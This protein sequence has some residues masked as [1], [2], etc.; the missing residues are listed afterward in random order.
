VAQ[1]LRHRTADTDQLKNR[2][3]TMRTR[4]YI[5]AITMAASALGL[6]AV[7]S[8]PDIRQYLKIRKM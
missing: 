8:L 6:L 1:R 7:M 4:G 3:H 2:R 5:S